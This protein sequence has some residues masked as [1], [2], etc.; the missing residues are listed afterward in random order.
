MCA[1]CPICYEKLDDTQIKLKCSHNFHYNC[2]LS[3]YNSSN[4]KNKNNY[5]KYSRNC[6]Y[7]RCPGGYLKLKE[8][9]YP[10]KGVHYK[11]YEIEKYLIEQ[12][13]NKVLDITKKY[14][15][16][17]KCHFILKTGV[18]KGYQCK[19]TKKD[20]DYCYLHQ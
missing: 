15:N 10:I 2:I 12:D 5:T 13:F 3:S 19:K 20:G 1:E 18:N 16:I 17:K 14:L 8:N 4:L 11:F 7:C 9:V 6:P